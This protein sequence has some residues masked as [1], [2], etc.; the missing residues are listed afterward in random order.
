MRGA[1]KTAALAALVI[2]T[3]TGCTRRVQVESEPSRA[4]VSA[5]SVG[6]IDITGTYD[7]VVDFDGQRRP[8][9]VTIGRTGSGYDVRMSVQGEPISTRNVRREGNTLTMDA[10][11]PGG[12]ATIEMVWRGRDAFTGFGYIGGIAHPVTG[13]RRP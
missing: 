4:E 10:T 5:A 1:L 3:A 6:T 11:T 8:G 9:I 2:A 12:A 7:Y 13:T